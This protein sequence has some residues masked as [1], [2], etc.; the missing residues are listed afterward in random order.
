MFKLSEQRASVIK[1]LLVENDIPANR[2]QSRGV[3]NTRPI[4]PDPVNDEER[5]QNMRVQVIVYR[6]I[7]KNQ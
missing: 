2:I 7:P 6:C 5:K 3:G 1:D 4:Y